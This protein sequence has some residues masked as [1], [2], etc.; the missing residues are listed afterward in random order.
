MAWDEELDRLALFVYEHLGE[1]QLEAA[2]DRA[3]AAGARDNA[4]AEAL[5]STV[6]AVVGAV[7]PEDAYYEALRVELRKLVRP[8]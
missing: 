3:V 6:T 8:H 5:V 2:V 4:R 7:I 1:E